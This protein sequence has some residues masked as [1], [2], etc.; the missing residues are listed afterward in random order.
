[1]TKF[2]VFRN[3]IVHGSVVNFNNVVVATKAWNMLFAVADWA[4]ATTKAAAPTEPKLGWR[5]ALESLQE[6]GRRASYKDGFTQRRV[7][8]GG[9]GFDEDSVV[10]RARALLETWSRRQWGKVV[11]FLP[12]NEVQQMGR[13]LAVRMVKDTLDQELELGDWNLESIDYGRPYGAD[14]IASATVNNEQG[15]LR[16]RFISY[17]A[18]G[19]VGIPGSP[20]VDWY[21]A[22][23]APPQFFTSESIDRDHSD[24]P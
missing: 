15:H 5:D 4:S 6:L 23:W 16:I 11:N 7:A 9:A 8:S 2:E 20:G 18:H 12:P 17:D 10:V 14:I 13:G 3:G 24:S 22:I 19:K 1:M 21:V